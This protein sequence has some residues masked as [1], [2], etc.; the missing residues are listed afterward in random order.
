M[1]IRFLFF[2]ALS[3]G[4]TSHPEKP[5][6]PPP[7]VVIPAAPPAVIYYRPAETWLSGK[8]GGAAWQ[9]S[10]YAHVLW[11]EELLPLKTSGKEP[12]A[13]AANPPMAPAKPAVELPAVEL[14]ATQPR[15]C[16]Q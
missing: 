5:P 11:R 8:L 6:V 3:T 15:P 12:A 14:I 7:V 13:L 2:I 16:P 10:G 9:D 1:R 4:C